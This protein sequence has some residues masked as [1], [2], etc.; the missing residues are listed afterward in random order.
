MGIEGGSV[1]PLGLTEIDGERYGPLEHP[2]D[3]FA[4]DIFSQAA[5]A[6][7]RP[8]GLDPLDGLQ[9]ER[10]IAVGQSQSAYYLVSYY[11]AVNP[12]MDI[13]DGYI[14]HSRGGT[15]A[16]L[17]QAPQPGVLAPALV[18]LREDQAEPVIMLQTETDLFSGLQYL[19]AR[20]P[21]SDSIRLWE[22]AGSAH[23]D[24]YTALKGASDQGN[25]PAI[26]EVISTTTARAPFIECQ[27]PIND[28]PTHWVAKAAV[29][30]M[31]Q[32]VAGEAEAPRGPRLQVN[33]D[34]SGFELDQYGNALDGIRTPYVDAPVAALS[35]LGQ[36]NDGFCDLFGTT[37]LFTD[38]ELLLLYPSR[39]A[40][41]DAIDNT[42]DAAV[43]S[44]FLLPKDA[45]LI[46]SQARTGE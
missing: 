43:A 28:G 26:A 40:Y 2:G 13:F 8:V 20:Q 41:I 46:K 6:V 4:Y 37:D 30:A 32:W 25:N 14:I 23:S 42:S 10:M 29:S 17:S 21:D 9:A 12:L 1:F 38:A 36:P 35:G 24:A 7:R 15:S 45:D 27:F 11:N 22:V 31:N 5:Q 16:P 44:G 34:Q 39:Q 19:P 18:R 3:S 33:G